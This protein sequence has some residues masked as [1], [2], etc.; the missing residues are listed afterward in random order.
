MAYYE[1]LLAGRTEAEEHRVDEGDIKAIRPY[2]FNWGKKEIAEGLV[3]IV[4]LPDMIEGVHVRQIFESPM[5]EDGSTNVEVNRRIAA[6]ADILKTTPSAPA[7]KKKRN[8]C[9]PLETLKEKGVPLEETKVRDLN[10]IYQPCKQKTQLLSKL[11][12]GER[13]KYV[14]PE[15]ADTGN[16]EE[17]EIILRGKQVRD[18]IYSKRK[19]GF[20]RIEIRPRQ[21]KTLKPETVAMP[22]NI[23]INAKKMYEAKK[24]GK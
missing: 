17:E 4:E 10:T 13:K 3:V 21:T 8:Y 16:N 22:L 1:L 18:L 6:A 12:G 11:Y 23:D 19:G 14:A 9:I 2:P 15:E 5:Y 20:K 7:E 24:E